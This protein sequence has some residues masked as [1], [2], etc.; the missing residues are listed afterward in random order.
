M[1]QKSLIEK[2]W[3]LKI[4]QDELSALDSSINFTHI[5]NYLRT[6]P[7][8]EREKVAQILWPENKAEK[9]RREISWLWL[10]YRNVRRSYFSDE[11]SRETQKKAMAL[12]KRLIK[13]HVCKIKQLS[14]PN[15]SKLDLFKKE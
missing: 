6:L 11:T 8:E 5:G 2:N 3:E 7:K 13:D 15:K 10:R 1:D 14:Q 4:A 9:H 12:Y